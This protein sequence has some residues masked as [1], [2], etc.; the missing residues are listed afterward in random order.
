MVY[1]YEALSPSA[2]A[3]VVPVAEE[4]QPI[5]SSGTQKLRKFQKFF[6]LLRMQCFISA[7]LCVFLL[8]LGKFYPKGA[9]FVKAQLVAESVDPVE[10]AAQ[11]MLRDI[12]SGNSIQQSIADFCREVRDAEN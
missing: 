6:R 1:D 12:F 2:P 9:D 10:Q 11:T 4:N 8:A 7:A 5:L 3:P